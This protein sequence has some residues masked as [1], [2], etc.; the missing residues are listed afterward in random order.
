MPFLNTLGKTRA[1]Q[2]G[3]IHTL[4][5]LS[6]EPVPVPLRSVS[7]KVRVVDFVAEITL[8]QEYANQEA[9]PIE[10][11]Y[12]FPVEEE[13]AVVDFE[14]TLE[15]RVI[16]TDVKEKEEARQEYKK[17][18]ENQ[19]TAFLLEETKPD[20]FQI[21]VGHLKPGATAKITI[22]YV[23]ELPVE[24]GSNVRLTIPTTIAPR[25]VPPT[26]DSE[27]AKKLAGISYS[28]ESSCPLKIEVDYLSQKTIKG[29]KSSS[30]SISSQPGTKE[31]GFHRMKTTLT[32]SVTDMDRDFI[33]LAATEKI[34]DPVVYV[35][36]N[37]D[38][39][40]QAGMVSLV[41]SFAL[42]EQ[43]V[44]LIFLVDRSGSMGGGYGGVLGGIEQAKKAL[45]LFLHSLP[46][47]CYFNIWSFGS[48]F[49]SLFP[50]SVLYDDASLAQAKSH[51]AEMQADY[52]GTEIY[53]PLEKI[54]AMEPAHPDHLRQIFVLTDGAV[55][56]D[57]K[58]IALV[59]QNG[60]K[61]R[62]F[63][64]GLGSSASRHLVKGI[65]RGGN[66]TA[67]FSNENDDLRPKVLSQLKNALQPAI[68]DVVIQWSGEALATDES[69]PVAPEVVTE[70]TLLGFMKPKEPEGQA[71][72]V[73]GQCPFVIPP[74]FDGTRLLAYRLFGADEKPKKVTITAKT[75]S[76]PLSVDLDVVKEVLLS[77]TFVHQ[78]AARKR[79]QDLEEDIGMFTPEKKKE[80]IV[81][82]AKKHRLASSHTSFIGIDD[83]D[84][85]K[86]FLGMATREITNQVPHGF[87]FGGAMSAASPMHMKKCARGGM[88]MPM[89]AFASAAPP[90]PQMAK[91][92]SRAPQPESFDDEVL[93]AQC[94]FSNASSEEMESDGSLPKVKPEVKTPESLETLI[95]LQ[96]SKGVFSWGEALE[97]F[98]KKTRAEVIGAKPTDLSEEQWITLVAI[99]VMQRQF[100]ADQD[101]WELV[102]DKSMK[103]L[104]KE[105]KAT[106][107]DGALNAAKALV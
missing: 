99:A 81:N 5:G 107:F 94:G 83:K 76:G 49:S 103:W 27:A 59:K 101:L 42:D 38:G 18:I 16:K 12:L 77:G 92:R 46:A 97:H 50:Q 63:S 45:D 34:H 2:C 98:A 47:D 9:R 43:K 48:R 65:A 67:V 71:I 30:H 70:K 62:V 57:T 7:L 8:E 28:T 52:G 54:F 55:S 64:L 88:A 20:V 95:A 93:Y 78:L 36:Q 105:S 10:A 11:V 72:P 79:I 87:N 82:L 37:P 91:C 41:P 13:A 35:E 17:A 102:V 19:K 100:V 21:Q 90:P 29:L 15:D 1:V 40:S 85:E 68:T 22:K 26:D 14:A 24:D 60:R 39:Q 86:V 33:L 66:G 75:P 106:D 73:L 4:E 25:Y 6:L 32:G 56:N 104:K 31:N 61:A 3:L 51:V 44:E 89:M 84:S 74:V 23:C 53:A 69:T 96:N 58:V 80:A